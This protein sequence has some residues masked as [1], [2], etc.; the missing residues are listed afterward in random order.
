MWND[1]TI[2]QAIVSASNNSGISATGAVCVWGPAG[3]AAK[4]ASY[5][6]VAIPLK[7]DITKAW[8]V[9]S[10][11][12]AQQSTWASIDSVGEAALLTSC[13]N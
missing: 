11:G 7:S 8:C 10:T 4:S 6:L 5:W 9:D 2:K 13:P 12:K 3:S 1:P